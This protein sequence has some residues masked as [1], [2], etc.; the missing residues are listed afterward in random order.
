MPSTADSPDRFMT[1]ICIC[2]RSRT[3][4]WCDTSHPPPM[5]RAGDRGQEAVMAPSSTGATAT[6]RR[7]V[8]WTGGGSSPAP[9][10][11]PCFPRPLRCT[12]TG[13][14][15][16]G[17]VGRGS[18][19]RA[20]PPLRAALP[21]LRRGARRAGVGPGPATT[22]PGDGGP[23]PARPALRALRR[24]PIR[25]GGLRAK[26]MRRFGAGTAAEHFYAEHVEAD[27]VHE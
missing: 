18:P 4:P 24:T 15:E 22:V 3:Y 7:P 10:S 12:R 25:R 17:S 11:R 1:A 8:C 26:A 9:S 20:L 21:G 23:L 2:R 13:G 14:S 5:S 27:A 19:P 16:S 6:A